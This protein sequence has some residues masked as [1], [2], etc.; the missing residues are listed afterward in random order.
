MS[1]FLQ[2]N[3]NVTSSPILE[4]SIYIFNNSSI[5]PVEYISK[6]SLRYVKNGF[7]N[8]RVSQKK[9]QLRSGQLLLTP[10]NTNVWSKSCG[11]I[12]G[13]SVFFDK[14]V[15]LIPNELL[16]SIQNNSVESIKTLF[17]LSHFDKNLNSSVIKSC[18]NEMLENP[19]S[20]DGNNSILI[21]KNLLKDTYSKRYK[22][23]SSVNRK[24]ISTKIDL[25]SRVESARYEIDS[26]CLQKFNLDELSK[27]ST[28]S[29]FALIRTFRDV[30]NITP[31]QYYLKKKTLIAKEFLMKGYPVKEVAHRCGYSDIYSF[32]KQFKL[33]EGIP[34]SQLSKSA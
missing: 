12:D 19:D 8:T 20:V 16:E 1:V 33:I 14:H 9:I 5:G 27:A 31:H 13:V 25:L 32:S 6:F 7:V 23:L 22:N 24:K 30:Y 3:T 15:D 17:R 18:F 28:M 26:G 10:Y 11:D 21:I 34:P 2:S 4:N 29:K